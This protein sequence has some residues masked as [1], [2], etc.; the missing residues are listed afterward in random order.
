MCKISVF[1]HKTFIFSLEVLSS[2]LSLIRIKMNAVN[3]F[4]NISG[5][6]FVFDFY[7]RLACIFMVVTQFWAIYSHLYRND[8]FYMTVIAIVVAAVTYTY[9]ETASG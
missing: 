3:L 4:L 2:R 7:P 9:A 5:A 1:I 8:P 6:S